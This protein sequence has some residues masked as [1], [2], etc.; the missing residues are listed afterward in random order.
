MSRRRL[1]DDSSDEEYNE[2]LDD[3]AHIA[4]AVLTVSAE[5][6]RLQRAEA[7][8]NNR[9]YLCRPQLLPNP[10]ESTPWQVLYHSQNHRAFITTMGIDCATFEYILNSGFAHHW[11]TTPIP[12][13][14]V[15]ATG[16]PRLGRRSLD[17]AGAL[18]LVYHYLT[19]AMSDTALQQIFAL[20]PATVARYRAF[21]LR[22]LR[23]TLRRLPE[24]QVLWW[25]SARECEEDAEL[26]R[27]RHPMI[28]G[29]IGGIDGMNLLTAAA[30]DPELENATYNGWLHGHY[31]SCVLVFSPKGLLKAAV[32]NAPGSWHDVKV[33]RPIYKKLREKTPNGYFIVADTAFPRGTRS[34]EGRIQA[35]LKSGARL[36]Q[37][38]VERDMLLLRN[39]QLVSFRQTAEWGVRQLRG[40]FGRLR[41]PLDINDDI[42]RSDLLEVCL[43]SMNLRT[44]RVGISQIRNV[45]MRIWEEAEDSDIWQA[46]EGVVFGQLRRRDHVA[47]FHHVVEE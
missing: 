37:D 46:F 6:A 25:S 26:I 27:V 15:H 30:D 31:T 10:R 24:A 2:E 12:R 39:R 34:I 4:A 38:R 18:G 7:R 29:A 16:E 36:P 19:S 41:V 22:I 32:F 45:Y 5:E 35:P 47:R 42:G 43:R 1:L 11:N 14:D 28:S 20:V 17:A 8:L 44:S 3:I 9:R 33:A 21:G 23:D 40:G 13:P